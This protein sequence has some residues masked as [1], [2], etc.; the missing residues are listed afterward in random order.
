VARTARRFF[1]SGV[2]G[3]VSFGGREPTRY[4][5]EEDSSPVDVEPRNA[6]RPEMPTAVVASKPVVGDP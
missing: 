4:F 2:V 1:R 5:S 3:R 6:F